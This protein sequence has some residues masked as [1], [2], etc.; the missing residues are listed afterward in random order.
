MARIARVVV[1]GLPHHVTQRGNRKQ[2]TFFCNGDYAY[3]KQLLREWTEHHRVQVWSYCLMPNHVHLVC[4]PSSNDGLARG[5]GETHRRYSLAINQREGWQGYLWQ[6]RFHST[7]LDEP[8]LIATVRYVLL[9]PVRAG[10]CSDP[11]DWEF[12]SIHEHLG[13][14]RSSI[15]E[16]GALDP[17][18]QD[19]EKLLNTASDVRDED[20]AR[21]V[22][23]GRPMGDQQFLRRLEVETGRSL[24]PKKRGPP[25]R[26]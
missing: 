19:I 11:R 9:N 24:I 8:H 16:R 25:K 26:S 5:V 2:K 22:R 13:D 10:L 6:G 20:I 4:R 17:F 18:I 3:Y 1:P 23:T 21:H 14:C 15:T 7:P 12:S